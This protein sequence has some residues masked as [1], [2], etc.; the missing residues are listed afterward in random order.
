[1]K[2]HQRVHN[3]EP[4]K[5]NSCQRAFSVKWDLKYHLTTHSRKKSDS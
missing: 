2:E 4:F 1:L 5:C 3:G